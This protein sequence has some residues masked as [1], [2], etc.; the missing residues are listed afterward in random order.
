LNPIR[1]F[2]G[3]FFNFKSA[4]VK[5]PERPKDEHFSIPA[6]GVENLKRVDRKREARVRGVGFGTFQRLKPLGR[7]SIRPLAGA[8]RRE[9][10]KLF[11][12]I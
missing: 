3:K 1:K 8:D 5:R 6:K 4:E 2:I 12:P 10:E 7:K 11:K 9:F